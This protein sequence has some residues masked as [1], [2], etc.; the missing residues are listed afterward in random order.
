MDI[1][2]WE[3]EAEEA[4]QK[5][6]GAASLDAWHAAY[7]G[8]KSRF[9]S[10]MRSIG[11]L[12]LA[13]KRAIAPKAQAVKK[14]L[15]EAYARRVAYFKGSDNA[16]SFDITLPG[17]KPLY[18]RPH[19]LTIALNDIRSIFSSMNFSVVEGPE[20]ETER[21]NFDSLNIPK[22]HPARDMQDT[23]WVSTEKGRLMRTQTSAMQ[24]RYMEQH[25]PPFQI[26]V[27]G[28][29]FR[30]EATDASHEINFYQFEG[31]MVGSDISLANLKAVIGVFCERFFER[32]IEMRFRPSYFP[33]TEPSV[34]IDIKMGNGAWLEVMGGGMVHPSVFEGVGYD[35]LKISGF[36]FGGGLDRFAMIK[37]GVSDIRLFYGADLRFNNQFL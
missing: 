17:I 15:E 28:R 19:L 26:I 3:R 7:L 21:Y 5:T 8:R 34:E 37:Y 29:V 11:A 10:F 31:L 6:E 32:P 36:A 23:L 1:G 16:T 35:P 33:F 22:N 30:N 25:I 27:P 14:S 4:L 20:L 24:A 2:A 18:G 9:N 12:S 13:E